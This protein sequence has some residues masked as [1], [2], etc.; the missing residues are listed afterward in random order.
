MGQMFQIWKSGHGLGQVR[1]A[2]RPNFT[3]KS[4]RF[5]I[6]LRQA[7]CKPENYLVMLQHGPLSTHKSSTRGHRAK[8]FFDNLFFSN[9]QYAQLILIKS[10]RLTSWGGWVDMEWPY[11][12]LQHIVNPLGSQIAQEFM[13]LGTLTT[14]TLLNL[15]NHW[16][17]INYET[18]VDS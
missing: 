8:L 18:Q 13:E 15:Y 9:N 12:S 3:T 6:P 1:T 2:Y 4:N 7:S 10:K 14:T 17:Q 16:K 11:S 5:W